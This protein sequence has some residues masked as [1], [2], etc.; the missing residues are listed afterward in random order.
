MVNS[1]FESQ[2]TWNNRGI[3]KKREVFQMTFSLSKSAF[4]VLPDK[5]RMTNFKFICMTLAADYK[6]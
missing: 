6:F 2:I 4:L 3:I 1:H 5:E